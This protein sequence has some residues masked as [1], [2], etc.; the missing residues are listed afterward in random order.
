MTPSEQS[1]AGWRKGPP[2]ALIEHIL[3]RYH[4]RHREQ[5]S[6]LV[7]LARTVERVHGDRDDC[8]PGLADHLAAMQQELE[9][10]MQKEEQ[11]L[12][13]LLARG[14][15]PLVQGP[16]AVM[17]MEHEQHGQ[18]LRELDAITRGNALPADACGTWRAL[19]DCIAEFRED[20]MQHIALENEVLFRGPDDDEV[21]Q[22]REA[23]RG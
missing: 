21:P 11:V 13:P 15:P 8:P 3:S 10:H 19:H 18:A 20:L 1:A 5:L 4:D 14:F 2:A 22:D 6:E 23:H 12:F 9:S 7:R 16:I 17:R